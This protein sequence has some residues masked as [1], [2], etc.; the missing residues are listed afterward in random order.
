MK[1]KNAGILRKEFFVSYFNLILASRTTDVQ[2]AKDMI[3]KK[4][5]RNNKDELGKVS[6]ENFLK[7]YEE[8]AK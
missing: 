1:I 5:F 8:I 3:F 4:F 6:Y 2:E 7:A